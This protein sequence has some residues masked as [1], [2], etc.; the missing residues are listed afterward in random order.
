MLRSCSARVEIALVR[1]QR[2]CGYRAWRVHFRIAR[3]LWRSRRSSRQMSRCKS[4]TETPKKSRRRPESLLGE[5]QALNRSHIIAPRPVKTMT[6][7]QSS[8]K[9]I[10]FLWRSNCVFAMTPLG[11][12]WGCA[13]QTAPKR[14]VSL[15]SLHL[16]R[17]VS[18]LCAGSKVRLRAP[19]LEYNGDLPDSNKR[20]PHCGWS[21]KSCDRTNAPVRSID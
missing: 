8:R 3:F 10:V 21:G 5:G 7:P 16:I 20:R 18:A 14:P 13:P 12:R 6:L 4:R 1:S 11:V 19:S 9:P 2:P 15:D 17:D